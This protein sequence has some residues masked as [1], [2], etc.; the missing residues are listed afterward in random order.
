[1]VSLL[2]KVRRG[3]PWTFA[4]KALLLMIMVVSGA[5]IGITQTKYQS[6]IGGTLNV[7]NQVSLVDKGFATATSSSNATG[8]CPSANVTFGITPGIANNNIT[9]NDYVYDAQ[10]ETTGSTPTLSCFTV[11]LTLTPDGGPQTTYTV[12]IA[13]G[14]TITANQTID[15]K[16]DIGTAL[17]TPPFTFLAKVL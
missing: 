10:V 1:M 7:A 16:F 9:M 2:E 8:N 5:S 17:P 4:V 15:C 12:K 11:S 14:A 3:L 13:S 6:E